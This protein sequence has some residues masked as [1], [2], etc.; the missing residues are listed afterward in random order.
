MPGSD[1][2][3]LTEK[4]SPL[5]YHLLSAQGKRKKPTQIWVVAL[6][7]PVCC[8]KPNGLIYIKIGDKNLSCECIYFMTSSLPWLCLS[9]RVSWLHLLCDGLSWNPAGTVI[10]LEVR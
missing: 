8:Q 5:L 10:P 6:P 4:L 1:D 3:L 2:K 7:L 9:E